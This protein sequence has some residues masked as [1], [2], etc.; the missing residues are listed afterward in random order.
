MRC[1]KKEDL[2][3][4][5]DKALP[6]E[7]EHRARSDRARHGKL[8]VNIFKVGRDARY[9]LSGTPQKDRSCVD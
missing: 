8:G 7:G 9:G 6:A 4:G 2:G 3:A 5:V 1:G